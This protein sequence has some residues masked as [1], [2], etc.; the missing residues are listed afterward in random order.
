MNRRRTLYQSPTPASSEL[1]LFLRFLRQRV[2]PDTRTLGP[3]P[4]RPARLG[5][6]VTQDELAEII[7]VSREWYALLESGTAKTRA[8]TGLLNR[9]AHALMIT[10][11]ERARLFHL[12]VP[13]LGRF[14]LRDDSI[15]VLQGYSR[16]R[17]LSKQLWAATSLDDVFTT[18]SEHI[19]GWFD[20]AVQVQSALRRDSAPWEH[21]PFDNKQDRNVVA[22]VVN[23]MKEVLLTSESGEMKELLR[24]ST[25]SDALNL[26]PAL[27]NAGDIGTPA[28][29]PLAV[30]REMPKVYARHRVGGFS[31][32]YARIRS[33]SGFIGGFYIAHEFGHSYSASDHAVLGA[34]A[35]LASY[36][37]S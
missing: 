28:L 4:R 31:G 10:E 17:S 34:F 8:S 14:Q 30:Q 19:A 6:R 25:L 21:R 9:L 13:E 15:A 1:P 37:L 35:E 27:A 33:R 22:K 23:D 26:H 36:A 5:K 12:G 18:A 20:D 7:G 2:D 11:D 3:Y 29:W 32:R 24:T 16:L